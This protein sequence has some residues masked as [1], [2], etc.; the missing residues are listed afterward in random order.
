MKE[1]LLNFLKNR[2]ISNKELALVSLSALFFSLLAISPSIIAWLKTPPG[3]V[4]VGSCNYFDPWD[5]NVYLSNISWG[6]WG[7]WL[8][9]QRYYTGSA[10][11]HFLYLFYIIL[12]HVAYWLNLS[13]PVVY[14]L[15]ALFLGMG[16]LVLG[17]FLATYFLNDRLNRLVAYALIC[18]GGG[19]G[20]LVG[21]WEIRVPDATTFPT[22][23][24]PHFSADQLLFLSS[25][26]TAYFLVTKVDRRFWRSLW[27]ALFLAALSV[28][29]PYMTVV[30]SFIITLFAILM[31][32]G[33]RS[34][35]FLFYLIFPLVIAV[36]AVLFFLWDLWRDEALRE[37]FL[38]AENFYI[39]T[40]NP[41]AI[42]L[43]YGAL[44]VFVIYG[45]W[46]YRNSRS[47][48]LL[49]LFT[50]LFVHTLSLYA[51]LHHQRSLLKNFYIVLALWG[52]QGFSFL[53]RSSKTWVKGT[54]AYLFVSLF[55]SQIVLLIF[56][57]SIIK[58]DNL[59]TYVS[60][61]EY[62]G[63]LWLQKNTAFG[64]VLLSS[65]SFGNIAPIY[66]PTTSVLS[67]V[68]VKLSEKRELAKQ[69]YSVSTSE[70]ERKSI[71]EQ[72]GVDF[73]VFGPR[74]RLLGNY[75]PAQSR[76]LTL[77]YEFSDLRIY[78]TRG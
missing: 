45:V 19:W 8:W 2:G 65:E 68:T 17:Y 59:Y 77:V 72:E 56:S 61:P 78:Q 20:W 28:I 48:K 18:F 63:L 47:E 75:D 1:A 66:A 5:I 73:V 35:S 11:A 12:G 16:L 4:F 55:F 32:K 50:W 34:V 67:H 64:D 6:K 53:F 71:I 14:H 9:Q 42:F 15:V 30:A 41:V 43:G 31:A 76:L 60:Q 52:A 58:A 33:R 29:H 22:L 70:I 10:S 39:P 49:F 40:P 37:H 26:V 46:R 54:A 36:G 51:P 23:R 27:L 13:G 7:H 21:A 25:L 44:S 69:F 24:V 3:Y 62:S 38:T 74:E 57:F